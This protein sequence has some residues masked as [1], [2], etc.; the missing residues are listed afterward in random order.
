MLSRSSQTLA[1][2]ASAGG[3]SQVWLGFE[4]PSVRRG[5]LVPC[6]WC[7]NVGQCRLTAMSYFGALAIM[8]QQIV[9]IFET[10]V[11]LEYSIASRM[12]S[13]SSQTLSCSASASTTGGGGSHE[14]L[15]QLQSCMGLCP[16]HD[17]KCCCIDCNSNDKLIDEVTTSYQLMGCLRIALSDYQH[18]G[19]HHIETHGSKIKRK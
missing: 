11:S 13:R 16:H 17:R 4:K 9:R 10:L 19:T 5:Q 12:L 15:L 14:P 1:C 7:H 8:P 3:M 6:V 18:T 2:S